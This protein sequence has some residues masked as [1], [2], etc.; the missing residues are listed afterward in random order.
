[1]TP[2]VNILCRDV[3]RA[4]AC[5]A[6]EELLGG[7]TGGHG[8][9]R[10]A[11]DEGG[12]LGDPLGGRFVSEVFFQMLQHADGGSFL[13][14]GMVEIDLHAPEEIGLRFLEPF[15]EGGLAVFFGAASFGPG[16]EKAALLVDAFEPGL[17]KSGKGSAFPKWG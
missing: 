2:E 10:S 6:G 7:G 1:M 17:A 11:F 12:E 8:F 9:E 13:V 3:E 5:P 15:F 4:W 16:L 14:S